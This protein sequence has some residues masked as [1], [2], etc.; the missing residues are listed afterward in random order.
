MMGEFHLIPLFEP[1]F[2]EG[3][4]DNGGVGD[5]R[6]QVL[7]I[8]VQA[9]DPVAASSEGR[10]LEREGLFGWGTTCFLVADERKPAPVWVKKNEVTAHGVDRRQLT[11]TPSN[12]HIEG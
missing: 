11:R 5:F 7:A 9:T 4:A 8:G 1:L 3:V 6:G 12:G 2:V 10:S